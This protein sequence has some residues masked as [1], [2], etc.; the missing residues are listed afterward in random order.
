MGFVE[1]KSCDGKI[2]TIIT[3]C[4]YS[5]PRSRKN[6]VLIDH[7][8]T[9]LQSL[10]NV[11]PN[12]GIIISGERNNI[13]ITTL[14]SIDPSLRQTVQSPTRGDK[15]L[16]VIVTNLARYF[17]TPVIIPP[18]VPDDPNKGAPVTTVE[19]LQRQILTQCKPTQGE[20]LNGSSGHSL[21]PNFMDLDPS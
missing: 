8:T 10:L 17:D 14:I 2:S 11:H 9:T 7:L 18:I 3:C 20:I 12:A 4:F 15:V 19:C 1:T 5:P 16:Y 21:N 6:I 13:D